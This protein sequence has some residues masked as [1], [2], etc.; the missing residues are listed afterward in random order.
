MYCCHALV[1]MHSSILEH[2]VIY[3]R[4][5]LM[6]TC[7]VSHSSSSARWILKPHS[8]HSAKPG[9]WQGGEVILI[10]ANSGWLL[11]HMCIYQL[12]VET[13]LDYRDP[14]SPESS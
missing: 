10:G 11:I 1:L 5:Y 7:S 14:T 3:L 6:H 12:W 2:E 9:C 4:L 8:G 13:P